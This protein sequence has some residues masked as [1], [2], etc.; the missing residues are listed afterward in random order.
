MAKSPHIGSSFD[1]F[2]NDEGLLEGASA[3]AI[4][5]VI[6]WQI[7]NAMKLRGVSKS[8]MAARMQTSRSHLDR[9]LDEDDCGLTI[10][11]LSRAASVLGMQVRLEMKTPVLA[12][13]AVNAAGNQKVVSK[14]RAVR[15]PRAPVS[16]KKSKAVLKKA[17]KG[18]RQATALKQSTG[19]NPRVL[20]I[21]KHANT[22]IKKI[23]N[24]AT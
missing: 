11:T 1:D 8:A 18:A 17:G 2:L 5:R 24:A 10:D 6:A 20:A 14:R 15:N 3:V 16:V 23:A 9:L 13:A 7:A 12:T 19:R 22:G 21:A 4:K